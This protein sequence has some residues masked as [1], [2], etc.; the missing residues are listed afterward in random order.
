MF[1]AQ[2]VKKKNNILTYETK[3]FKKKCDSVIERNVKLG[4]N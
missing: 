3:N 4:K 1:T 2:N